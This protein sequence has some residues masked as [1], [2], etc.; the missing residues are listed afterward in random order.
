M[1]QLSTINSNAAMCN[2][3]SP[4]SIYRCLTQ[5]M[6]PAQKPINITIGLVVY[7]P[8]KVD[9]KPIPCLL[10]CLKLLFYSHTE[11]A[12]VSDFAMPRDRSGTWHTSQLT[13]NRSISMNEEKIRKASMPG[14]NDKPFASRPTQ[15]TVVSVPL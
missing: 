7:Y 2:K 10:A 1:I 9:I 12:A 3:T 14:R 8:L 15:L 6:R 4:S 13:T 11:S 5:S